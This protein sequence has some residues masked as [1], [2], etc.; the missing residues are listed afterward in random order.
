M[1]EGTGKVGM[2][3]QRKRKS[4]T[5]IDVITTKYK[6][7]S[8]W[9]I[10]HAGGG[11]AAAASRDWSAEH[12]IYRFI[13]TAT[14]WEGNKDSESETGFEFERQSVYEAKRERDDYT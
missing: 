7:R 8:I 3:R 13:V 6:E 14:G 2:K 4:T 10:I 1:E 5:I 11:T 12:H 9:Q